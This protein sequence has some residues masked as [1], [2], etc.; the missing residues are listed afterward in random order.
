VGCNLQAGLV[1]LPVP[2]SH[3]WPSADPVVT[4]PENAELFPDLQHLVLQ[5]KNHGR[6]HVSAARRRN[7]CAIFRRRRPELQYLVVSGVAGSHNTI[8]GMATGE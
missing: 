1:S 3:L 2:L 7:A 8:D 4:R 5:A 6:F